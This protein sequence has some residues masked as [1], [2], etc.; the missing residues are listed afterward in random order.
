MIFNYTI[1]V[2]LWKYIFR[3]EAF[4]DGNLNHEMQLLELWT[5]LQPDSALH[6]RKT[7][8]WQTIGQSG[9]PLVYRI[10]DLDLTTF[11]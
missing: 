8:Q 11:S 7:K 5:H 3:S 4:D 1:I 10:S 6:K 9:S 2:P